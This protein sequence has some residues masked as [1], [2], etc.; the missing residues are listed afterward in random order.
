MSE[1]EQEPVQPQAVAGE[2]A[3]NELEAVAG[4]GIIN[5]V[6]NAVGTAIVTTAV[7]VADALG[8]FD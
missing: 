8:A 1:H 5:D 2:L 7:K 4:G 3:E 6:Y